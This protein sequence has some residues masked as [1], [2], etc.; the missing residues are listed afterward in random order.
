[1]FKKIQFL[2]IYKIILITTA[3]KENNLCVE[4]FLSSS[5]I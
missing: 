1:M 5:L 4:N 3:N 2:H